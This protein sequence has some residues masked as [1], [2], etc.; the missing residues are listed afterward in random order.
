MLC[1][2]SFAVFACK[3]KG[4]SED[5]D[6]QYEQTML[7]LNSEEDTTFKT[8]T[9]NNLTTNF[10]LSDF[11][12]KDSSNVKHNSD[13][14]YIM[15]TGVA[16]NYIEKYGS[17][18]V[19]TKGDYDYKT[20]EENLKKLEDK[21][22]EMKVMHTKLVSVGDDVNY[23]IYN[24]YFTNYKLLVKDF[25]SLSYE[26]ATY[27]GDLLVNQT[28]LADKAVR[29]QLTAEETA[30]YYDYQVLLV[31]QD[32]YKFFI[33]SCQGNK[34]TT[35]LYNAVKYEIEIYCQNV[36]NKVM[37]TDIDKV[38]QFAQ[39]STAFNNERKSLYMAVEKVSLY[40]L[41]Y[42]YEDSISAYGK[43][44]VNALSYYN[45]YERYFTT[46]NNYISVYYSF[47]HSI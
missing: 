3:D 35:Q 47:I 33:E 21:F 10:Y 2:S 45:E 36:V 13:D 28:G 44:E 7:S 46:T 38:K 23:V 32:F 29:E 17:M 25:I 5:T 8:D 15:L 19:S 26:T 37:T 39:L 31:F 16:L 12:E 34:L 42:R 40:D 27:L 20:L 41:S 43:D 4:N 30:A 6:R 18:I 1:L 24:G 9:I 11:V 14:N 22:L